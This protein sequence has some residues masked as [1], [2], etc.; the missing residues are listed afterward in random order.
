MEC[1]N[2]QKE[3]EPIRK[4]IAK[5]CSVKCRVQ[6]GRKN[7]K[8]SITRVQAQV[9]YNAMLELVDKIQS[10][11]PKEAYDSAPLKITYDEPTKFSAP[12]TALKSFDYYRMAKKD[13]EVEE[14]WQKMKAE[15]EA[16]TH[17]TAKQ[18]NILLT[19]NV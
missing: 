11:P 7:P 2:C 17:L 19:T 12:K 3:F 5:F 8:N 9:L 10:Q 4:D 16:A 15:I 14:D 6:H 18:K 13:I 1:L